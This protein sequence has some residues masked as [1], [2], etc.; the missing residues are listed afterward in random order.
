MSRVV[1]RCVGSAQVEEDVRAEEL[2]ID[3]TCVFANRRYK[4]ECIVVTT[5]SGGRSARGSIFYT[6]FRRPVIA[7]EFLPSSQEKTSQGK[8]RVCVTT[9][10]ELYL[11]C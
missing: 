5:N 3:I 8:G 9:M 6:I 10:F 1:A 2:V 11:Q 4:V 7:S